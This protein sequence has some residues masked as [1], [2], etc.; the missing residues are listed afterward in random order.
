[1]EKVVIIINSEAHG[2]GKPSRLSP[3]AERMVNALK[4]AIPETLAVEV[5]SAASLWSKSESPKNSKNLI[6]CPLTIQLP[7]G[8]D[9]PGRTIYQN[10]RDLEARRT[11]VEQKLAFQTSIGDSWLGD[12]WLPIVLTPKGPLYGEVIGEGAM[13]NAYQQPIDLTDDLRQ[14]LYY[15]AHQLLENI[16]APPSVY[17]LQ[18]SL[19][20][21]D[22][23]FDRLWPFPA[24]PAIA[25]IKIQNPNLYACYWHCL[26]NQPILDLAIVP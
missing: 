15:L 9:F 24:A 3:V 22:I 12:L 13:P 6:Y 21:K 25:S 5:I 2:I 23:V 17:L 18:F 1:M 4:Q 20:G 19:L 8:F 11:W 10:C 14:P 7:L 26:T 16:S